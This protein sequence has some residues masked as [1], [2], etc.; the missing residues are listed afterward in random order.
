MGIVVVALL[1]ERMIALPP[2]TKMTSTLKLTN[3]A[4]IPR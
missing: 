1:A 4:A 3:S 2:A